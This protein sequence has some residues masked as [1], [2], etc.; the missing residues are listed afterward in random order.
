[1]VR[2]PR[3]SGRG[4]AAVSYFIDGVCRDWDLPAPALDEKPWVMKD[5]SGSWFIGVAYYCAILRSDTWLRALDG[6]LAR[7]YV[8]DDGATKILIAQRGTCAH[9][10][11]DPS[12]C[13]LDAAENASMDAQDGE[14]GG[15]PK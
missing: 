9:L 4:N 10:Y 13:L 12:I 14:Q 11:S 15:A 1:M 5:D 7:A 6:G 2:R 8:R 3:P